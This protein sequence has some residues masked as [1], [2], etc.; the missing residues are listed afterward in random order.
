MNFVELL[1]TSF[2]FQL[3]KTYFEGQH[4]NLRYLVY[5]GPVQGANLVVRC[6]DPEKVL[7][8]MIQYPDDP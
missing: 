7:A 4:P 5:L 1:S 8:H 2:S 3:C 6:N